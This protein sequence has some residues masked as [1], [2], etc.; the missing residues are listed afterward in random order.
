MKATTDKEIKKQLLQKKDEECYSNTRE[1]LSSFLTNSQIDLVLHL[2]RKARMWNAEDMG[3]AFSLRYLNKKCYTYLRNTL[4]YP[5]P[6][7][8]I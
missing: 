6:D 8:E 5:L 4:H 2:K 1:A 3:I 7:K